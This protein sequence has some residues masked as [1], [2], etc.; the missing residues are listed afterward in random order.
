MAETQADTK[1]VASKG[2]TDSQLNAA[3]NV[4]VNGNV[5]TGLN[6]AGNG[7]VNSNANV[8]R[9]GIANGNNNVN[10]GLNIARNGN[11]NGNVSNAL[12]GNRAAAVNTNLNRDTVGSVN[13]VNKAQANVRQETVRKAP[14]VLNQL[15]NLGRAGAQRQADPNP[16]LSDFL[17]KHAKPEITMSGDT[18]FFLRVDSRYHFRPGIRLSPFRSFAQPWP[19]PQEYKSDPE[20]VFHINPAT[21]QIMVLNKTSDILKDAIKRYTEII[22]KRSLEE[23]Y[24]FVNNFDET[25]EKYNVDDPKKYETTQPL[26]QLSV[27]V[28]GSD[29][30]YPQLNYNETCK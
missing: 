22:L 17:S 25:F 23:P 10:T 21:F 12:T 11:V 9:N 28:T 27:Y 7:N 30:G 3:R 15:Q 2:N 6:V 8:A 16:Y 1:V 14:N 18:D 24:N 5:K 29:V 26:P 13:D 4:I 19:Y 20:T